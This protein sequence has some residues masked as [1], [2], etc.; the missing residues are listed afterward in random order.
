MAKNCVAGWI[1]QQEKEANFYPDNCSITK[2]L[3]KR[4]QLELIKLGNELNTNVQF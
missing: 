1:K 2:I 3:K 4:G